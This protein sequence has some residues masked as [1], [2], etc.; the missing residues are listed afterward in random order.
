M[1]FLKLAIPVV[2]SAKMLHAAGLEIV[3]DG[4][5]ITVG[6]TT[7]TVAVVAQNKSGWIGAKI[8]GT[9]RL[10]ADLLHS[11]DVTATIEA[12]AYAAADVTP[13]DEVMAGI[14]T[15]PVEIKNTELV[16]E[17]PKEPEP[18][19][20]PEPEPEPTGDDDDAKQ[21][22]EALHACKTIRFPNITF[23]TGKAT[24]TADGRAYVATVA[25]GLRANSGLNVELHGHTD[26]QG[27]DAYNQ[28]LSMSRAASVRTALVTVHGIDQSRMEAIGFGEAKPIDDNNT[29]AGRERNR[30]VE[31]VNANCN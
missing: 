16:A 15:A 9:S 29:A 11:G 30:R 19:P 7:G 1:R 5:I 31:I 26:S 12:D 6:P 17:P 25:G 3:E 2:L 24:L 13:Q 27:N 10:E 8:K 22:A 21:V 14:A 20:P 23:E 4:K 18:T 28:Q